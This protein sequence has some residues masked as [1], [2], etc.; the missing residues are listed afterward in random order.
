MSRK[1]SVNQPTTSVTRIGCA[2]GRDDI[3]FP[4]RKLKVSIISYL[5]CLISQK[6]AQLER[7]VTS[8]ERGFERR[9]P[10]NLRTNPL[11]A[12][13]SCGF[14]MWAVH[15]LRCKFRKSSTRGSCSQ[16]PVNFIPAVPFCHLTF[17]AER[18]PLRRYER[19]KVPEGTLGAAFRERRWSRGLEQQ[20]AAAE[21]G[22]SVKTYAGWETNSREPNLRNIPA[23][24]RFLG[25]DWRQHGAGLGT[26]IRI[27]RTAAGLSIKQL[28]AVLG[29]DAS[30]VADW[31]AG[32]HAPSKRS[33]TKLHKW[34]ARDTDTI[35]S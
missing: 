14:P 13:D 29:A 19:V 21:I 8:R 28:A 5:R 11:S 16:R 9:G 35:A 12:L 2:I 26:R 22:V 4:L 20:G 6:T 24:I 30:T 33:A 31:E 15:G 3:P 23:S 18:P 7:P 34:L 27:A 17:L 1:T 25:F 10:A 32:L